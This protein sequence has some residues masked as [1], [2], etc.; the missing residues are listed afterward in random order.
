MMTEPTIEEE[1]IAFD[2]EWARAW[3]GPKN[4]G[5]E[6]LRWLCLWCSKDGLVRITTRPFGG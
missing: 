6:L 5:P 4:L 1:E 3:L 2:P